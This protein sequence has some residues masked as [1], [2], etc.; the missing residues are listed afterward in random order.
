MRSVVVVLPASMCAM[1]PILRVFSSEYLRGIG[2]VF[3]GGGLI[4]GQKKR[5]LGPHARILITV[6][7]GLQRY[8]LEVSISSNLVTGTRQWRSRA[9]ENDYSSGVLR[10]WT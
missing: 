5:P 1:N 7:P 4:P 2:E 9:T 8:V 3:V 6:G 10:V